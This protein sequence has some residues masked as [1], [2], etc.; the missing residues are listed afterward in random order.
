MVFDWC[1]IKI[2][3][4]SVFNGYSVNIVASIQPGTFLIETPAQLSSCEFS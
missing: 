2:H 3:A 1:T 4:K